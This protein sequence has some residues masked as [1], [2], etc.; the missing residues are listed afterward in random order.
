VNLPTFILR[1]RWLAPSAFCL[2]TLAGCVPTS[3][4]EAL[5][6]ENQELQ[7]SVDTLNVQIRQMQAQ[8]LMAQQQQAQAVELQAR[9]EQAKKEAADKEE[10]MRKLEERW[11]KYKGDRRK[12]LVGKQ[13]SEIALGDG[14]VLKNAEITG[15]V[16]DQLSIRHENGLAKVELALGGDD[17]RWLACFDE[18][19]SADNMR[20]ARLGRAKSLGAQLDA[21]RTPRPGTSS[22]STTT[23]PASNEEAKALRKSIAAQRAA[24]N[25][26]YNRLAAKNR[27][28]LCG[29]H[30][31]SSRPEDSGLINVFAE[32]RALLG[33]GE[34][35]SLATSIKAG[36]RKLHDLETVSP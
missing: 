29:T 13:F 5:Q 14:R 7:K 17:I 24:L 22:S 28:A 9:L 16:D 31:N 32:R 15:M 4:Y 2:L 23:K 6:K 36:L 3:D 18:E 1:L 10:E 25:Q 19:E 27:L 34:L 35:D 20:L 12:A 21:S 11:E 33:F 30:W 8:L 26:A